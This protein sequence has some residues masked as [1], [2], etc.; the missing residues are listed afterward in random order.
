[1]KRIL[2]VLLLSSIVF[3]PMKNAGAK[4]YMIGILQM[5]DVPHDRD[6][7]DGFKE[8]LGLSGV[9]FTTDLRFADGDEEKGRGFVRGWREKNYDMICTIGTKATIWA[10]EEAGAIPI[11]F[12]AVTNPVRSGIA[13]SWERPGRNLTGTSNWIKGEDKL[14]IFKE[15]IPG[16]KRLGVIYDPDNP[17][18]AAEIEDA[19]RICGSLDITLIEEGIKNPEQIKEAVVRLAERGMDVLWVPIERS[20]YQHMGMITP[21]TEPR[22]IPIVSSTIAGIGTIEHPTGLIALS[23]DYEK[24]GR[25]CAVSAVEILTTGKKPGDIPI[26]ILEHQEIIVN[27]NLAEDMGLGCP[28]QFMAMS[29]EVIRGYKGQ[30]IEVGGTGDSQGLLRE[31]A[32]KKAEA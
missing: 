25:L 20:V 3:L 6:V 19:R 4:T 9:P 15:G 16:L 26:K 31:I 10:M 21:V 12:T 28:L 5:D 11:V 27:A 13:E 23:V 7:V 18:P 2:I 8:G 30:R 14:K 32:R 1:M 29:T 22:K 17:V 24:L